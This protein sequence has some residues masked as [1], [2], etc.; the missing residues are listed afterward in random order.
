M[1]PSIAKIIQCSNTEKGA[2]LQ[3]YTWG[4]WKERRNTKK[5]HNINQRQEV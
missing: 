5:S 4:S 3:T 1:T 2:T